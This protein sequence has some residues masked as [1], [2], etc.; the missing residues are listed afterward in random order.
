MNS[1][2]ESC[3]AEWTQLVEDAEA[4][5]KGTCVKE[6]VNWAIRPDV[7]DEFILGEHGEKS[8]GNPTCIPDE[9]LRRLRPTLLIRH[10][11]LVVPSLLRTALDNEG[12]EAMMEDEAEEEM[13][14]EVGYW[15]HV[16]IYQMFAKEKYVSRE[17]DLRYPIV[18]DAADLGNETLVRKYAKM[19][20]LDANRL[21]FAWDVESAEGM[22]GVEA[23][24]RDT[25]MQSQGVVA[26]KLGGN[27]D[28]NLE[29]L[30]EKW[31]EEF[32]KHLGDI[33]ARLVRGV[34]PAYKWLWERRLRV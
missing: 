14:R 21:S 19:I 3:V 15:W 2:L 31:N 27:V 32:G 4:Q 29:V 6:H 5:G 17:E 33:V 25:L 10:P 7:E 1:V 20:G 8:E 30:E 24:M 9:F 28:F 22:G 16:A 34:I 26:E 12:R 23:R 18:L 13:R 11:A